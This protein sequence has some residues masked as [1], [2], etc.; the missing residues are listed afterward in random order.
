MRDE[1]AEKLREPRYPI[2]AWTPRPPLEMQYAPKAR[3]LELSTTTWT[4]IGP[5]PLANTSPANPN[6]NVSGRIV[7]V[8]A[9]PTDSN[10]IYIATAGGGVWRTANG[11]TNWTPLTDSQVTLSMGALA[12]A[13]SN[14]MVI[15][16]GTGEA[17]NSLDSNCG[18]GI[19]VSGDGGATWTL[20]TGPA[21]VFSV[22][23][24]A[25]S[26]IVVDPTNANVAYV[27]MSGAAAN[28][29]FAN[30]ITGVYKTTR[31][32]CDLD[33]SSRPPMARIR[34]SHGLMLRWIRILPRRFTE[35][36][37]TYLAQPITAAT[38]QSIAAR[39]GACSMQPTRRSELPSGELVSRYRNRLT[40]MFFTWRRKTTP[41]LVQLRGSCDQTTAE[42]VS[43]T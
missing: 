27:A 6:F 34:F 36:S 22:N 10:T 35:R 41:R 9:H 17:N 16:A 40:R 1:A 28:G 29:V 14:P 30:G 33:Q 43:R 37:A 18:R 15:Y 32:W 20:R 42:P 2:D 19:L 8:A 4:S 5:S 23:R 3:V 11:G 25:C 7:A 12:I 24:M 13:K 38:N 39:I 26:K 21:N 31:C